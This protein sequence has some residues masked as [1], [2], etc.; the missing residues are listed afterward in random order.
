VTR[1]RVLAALAVWLRQPIPDAG[2]DT[3]L[4]RVLTIASALGFAVLVWAWAAIR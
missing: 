3:R 1:L 4:D 2:G